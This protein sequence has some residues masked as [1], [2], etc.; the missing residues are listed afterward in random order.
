MLVA[1]ASRL[2]PARRAGEGR[3]RRSARAAGCQ[4]SRFNST[5]PRPETRNPIPNMSKN[6]SHP[7]WGA[8]PGPWHEPNNIP[9]IY[10]ILK[11][12]RTISTF[13]HGPAFFTRRAAFPLSRRPV[14]PKSDEG[15]SL[16]GGGC[17]PVQA[18]FQ[19]PASSLGEAT[20]NS[21]QFQ[22]RVCARFGE[23]SRRDGR[24]GLVPI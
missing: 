4:P 1:Q 3:A 18:A 16:G 10:T 13:F 23:K 2:P 12:T 7:H 24:P 9:N 5:R 14:A 20:D 11:I 21:P 15:G 22:L 19:P 8:A 6:R 17:P